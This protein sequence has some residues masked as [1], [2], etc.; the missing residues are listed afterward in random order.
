MPSDIT[1]RA[2]RGRKRMTSSE[3]RQQLITVARGLFAQKGL[4]GTSVEQIAARAQV[5]KPVVY[6]HFGGKEGLYAVIVDREMHSL[7]D[8]IHKALAAPGD[9]YRAVIESAAMAML[10]YIDRCPDGFRII[11]RDSASGSSGSTFASILSDITARVEDLL[12][13]SL[14]KRGYDPY[15][16]HVFAQGLVGMIAHAGLYWLDERQPPK[17][18]LGAQLANLAWNGLAHLEH[19]PQLCSS[20]VEARRPDMTQCLHENPA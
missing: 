14:E 2:R 18:E 3:R 20:V 11:S 5:S 16:G 4:E 6:E 1:Q 13:V 9:G 10:D 8:A 7:E 12:I 15:L 19:D 17:D